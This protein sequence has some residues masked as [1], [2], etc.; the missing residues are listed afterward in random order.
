LPEPY[1]V[2]DELILRALIGKATKEE[3]QAIAAWRAA[4][5]HHEQDYQH[6]AAAF[7]AFASLE[8]A[9]SAPPVP[10]AS[11]LIRR[12]ERR[13]GSPG[14]RRARLVPLRWMMGAAAAAGLLLG[15]FG[16]SRLVRRGTS[17]PTPRVQ[18]FVTGPSDLRAIT[19]DDG[20]LIRLGPKSDL[21]VFP[22]V[23]EV[24][25]EGRAEFSVARVAGRWFTVHTRAGDIVDLATRF[26]VR[27][28][29]TTTQVTV[30]EGRVAMSAAGDTVEVGVGDLGTVV[31]GTR[32]S[33]IRVASA[34]LADE[35]IRAGLV[36]ENSPLTQVAAQLEAGYGARIQLT[37]RVLAKRTVTAW[38]ADHPSFEEAITAICGIVGA[39]CSVSGSSARI[40]P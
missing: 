21:R 31:G 1:F 10:K 25:L 38:F 36:F 3:A 17:P 39:R 30:F 2:D 8:S 4:A 26:V 15:A 28:E 6:L 37:D 18:E 34:R 13:A 27:T 19:L 29:R 11:E 9:R 16:V 7:R 40:A 32:P 20:T 12:A 23:R 14:F 24:W 35:W 22:Q 5:V 33:V